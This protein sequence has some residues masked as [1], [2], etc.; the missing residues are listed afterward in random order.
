MVTILCV[1]IAVGILIITAALI[2]TGAFDKRMILLRKIHEV[3]GMASWSELN[4]SIH[5]NFRLLSQYYQALNER[6]A[7][8]FLIQS[9]EA[10]VLTEAGRDKLR[11]K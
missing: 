6:V 4:E 1:S 7:G 10:Y 5:G 2:Y 8:G 3:G 9:G 11:R